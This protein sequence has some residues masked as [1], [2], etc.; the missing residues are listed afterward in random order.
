MCKEVMY[1][2]FMCIY[3]AFIPLASVA[4]TN[5]Y[6]ALVATKAIEGLKP[7]TYFAIADIKMSGRVSTCVLTNNNVPVIYRIAGNIGDL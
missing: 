5:T 6:L 2:M 3:S 4:S 1:V 7:R